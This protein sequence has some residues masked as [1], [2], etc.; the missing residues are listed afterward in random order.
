MYSQPGPVMPQP[1]RSGMSSGVIVLLWVFAGWPLS[2][3]LLFIFAPLGILFGIGITVWMIVALAMSSSGGAQQNVVVNVK[4]MGPVMP[5]QGPP[6]APSI[7]E[8]VE[9]L[10][11]ISAIGGCGWCG[12]TTAH[13]ND[14]GYL[15]H[16]RHWHAAEIEERIRAK[17]LGGGRS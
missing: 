11:S 14:H 1:P 10:A 2:W 7:R 8:Q 5:R 15:V 17:T 4:T 16:P 13:A 12:S 9:G 6:S 3:L